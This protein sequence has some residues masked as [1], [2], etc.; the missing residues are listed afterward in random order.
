MSP[1]DP[2]LLLAITAAGVA[3][4]VLLV[5]W[6]RL[7]AVVALAIASIAVGIAARMPLLDIP[8][9]FQQGLGDTLGSV[10]LVIALGAMVGKLL[11]ESGGAVVAS[12]ALVNA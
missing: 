10:A 5:T 11:A 2:V 12:R 8:R 1:V 4:I 9:A 3:L 6:L 7:N